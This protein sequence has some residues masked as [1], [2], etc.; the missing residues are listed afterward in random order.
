MARVKPVLVRPIEPKFKTCFTLEICQLGAGDLP[1]PGKLMRWQIVTEGPIGIMHGD[2][3]GFVAFVVE[4]LT[5]NVV[6]SIPGLQLE[7]LAK[8]TLEKAK[9]ETLQ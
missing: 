7:I 6:A 4:Q 9:V 2:F 3:N 8:E 5:K 1:E